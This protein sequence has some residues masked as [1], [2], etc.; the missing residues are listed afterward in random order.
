MNFDQSTI[1]EKI[2]S[3]R[4][5]VYKLEKHVKTTWL[6]KAISFLDLTTLGSDDTPTKIEALCVKVIVYFILK[7]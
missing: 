1:D 2:N 3:I 7:Y 6:I 5:R 4:S